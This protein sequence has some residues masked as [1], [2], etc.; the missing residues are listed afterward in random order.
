MRCWILSGWLLFTLVSARAAG[1]PGPRLVFAHYM[2][3]FATYGETVDAYKREI[4]EAQA[5]GIDGFALNIGAW[6]D[7]Q[8]YYK[9]RV[10]LMYDAAEQLGTG[11]KL[12]FSVDFGEPTNVVQ[13][14]KAY[15]NRAAS[16]RHN[17]E[18]V[19]SAYGWNDVPSKGWPGMD[20]THAI[21]GKLEQDGLPIFFIPYFFSD[22]VRE[23]PS[24]AS[25]ASILLKY[26]SLLDGI[27]WW[28]AA[29]LP[30]ELVQSNDN[31]RRAARDAGKLFMASVAP[32][33]WGHKQPGLGRRYYEFDGGEGMVLQW[34]ALITNRPDWI[35]I[36][37]WNDFN[38][39]TYVAPVEDAGAYFAELKTPQRSPHAGYLE[40][41]KRY[42][43]WFK[44]GTEPAID[45]DELFYFY[46]PHPKDAVATDTND[47]PVGWRTGDVQDTLHLTAYLIAPAE[48]QIVS[49]TN[50]AFRALPAGMSHVRVPFVAGSQ[51]FT[52]RRATY[53]VLTAEGPAISSK[54][55]N[56]N[57]FP[58]SG[59]ARSSNARP[60]APERVQVSGQSN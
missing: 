14:V 16:L 24:Y 13:M 46:R 9:K 43:Q 20:W 33:Y 35:E 5:A 57:F 51:H 41:S 26:G 38:E 8:S 6:D 60:A 7:I 54:I 19:L 53:T 37:T 39:S 59:F 21:I 40:L 17:G 47:F 50:S 3:C 58:V 29:G 11:F 32:A 49:G 23:L 55:V 45:R 44:T 12:F 36:N 42:I 15:G 18:I 48:L 1:A 30:P 56:Y 34:L 27:F 2:V 52:L 22:P 31:Y 28:G 25:G 4:N 10:A